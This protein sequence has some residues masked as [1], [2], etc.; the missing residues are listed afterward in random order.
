MAERV[1]FAEENAVLVC[2]STPAC[3][4]PLAECRPVTFDKFQ[5]TWH[6]RGSNALEFALLPTSEQ[7]K[8]VEQLAREDPMIILATGGRALFNKNHFLKLKFRHR[9]RHF[10]I[11]FHRY[12]FFTADNRLM[13]PILPQ[14]IMSIKVVKPNYDL[15]YILLKSIND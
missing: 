6:H 13:L 7:S 12:T 10:I 5:T 11:F 3:Q 2:A 8:N 9:K 14:I 15:H 4:S 1:S